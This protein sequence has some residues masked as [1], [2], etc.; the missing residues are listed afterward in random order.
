MKKFVPFLLAMVGVFATIGILF[1]LV[2]TDA[3]PARVRSLDWHKAIE[4]AVE[5]IEEAAV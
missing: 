1:L 3:L 5:P 2:R 4:D